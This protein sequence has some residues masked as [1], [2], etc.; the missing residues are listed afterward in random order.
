MP[1]KNDHIP[2]LGLTL[3]ELAEMFDW[4]EIE[5]EENGRKENYANS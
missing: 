3:R 1:I 2:H 5:I 4:Q